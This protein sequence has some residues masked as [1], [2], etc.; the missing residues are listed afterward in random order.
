MAFSIRRLLLS[1]KAKRRRSDSCRY[2]M[3][4]MLLLLAGEHAFDNAKQALFEKP[5]PQL[6]RVSLHLSDSL[7]MHPFSKQRD[8]QVHEAFGE[9]RRHQLFV[10]GGL[11]VGDAV[12]D[13]R[14]RPLLQLLNV[15]WCVVKERDLE[16]YE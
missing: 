5:V 16:I 13:D 11:C 4:C 12:F 9:L 8:E 14:L 10:G 2:E 3:W 7:L 15:L 6:S 1:S